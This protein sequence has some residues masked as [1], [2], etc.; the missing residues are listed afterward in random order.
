MT[1]VS[2][3]STAECPK[4]STSTLHRAGVCLHCGAAPTKHNKRDAAVRRLLARPSNHSDVDR[5]RTTR[6]TAV[7]QGAEE[8][9]ATARRLRREAAEEFTP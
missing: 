6:L 9:A 8:M 1:Q 7:E 5:T 4:C 3:L 2:D